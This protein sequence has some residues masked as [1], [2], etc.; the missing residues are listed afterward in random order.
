MPEEGEAYFESKDL[1]ILFKIISNHIYVFEEIHTFLQGGTKPKTDEEI[2]EYINE[3]FDVS[4]STLA[5]V[6]FRL[7]W[8]INLGKVIKT[9]DDYKAV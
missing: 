1:E 2:L 6:N 5:Q 4:W 7:L 3:N 9:N 8:L